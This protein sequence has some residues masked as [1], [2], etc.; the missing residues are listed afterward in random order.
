MSDEIPLGKR[1]DL[2]LE[3]KSAD[4]LKDPEKIAREVVAMLNADGGDVWVGLGEDGEGRAVKVEAIPEPEAS[5]QSL[6]DFLSDSIEPAPSSSEISLA[7]IPAQDG[8]IL[9]ISVVGPTSR[10]YAL[11]KKSG[12]FY[13]RRFDDRILP[14]SREELR[15]AFVGT[16]QSDDEKARTESALR[17]ELKELQQAPRDPSGIF[18]LRIM[19]VPKL[20]VNLDALQESDLLLDPSA[21]GN[22]RAGQTFFLAG[23]GSFHRKGGRLVL[24]ETNDAALSIYRHDGIQLRLPLG[25]FHAG[26]EPGAEKPLYWLTLLEV[27]TSVFRLLSK[28]LRYETLWEE[29]PLENS[30]F[31][32]SV[33]L[34]GLQGWTLRP[35]S[36]QLQQLQGWWNYLLRDPHSSSDR[37]F[38]LAQPF[39]FTLRAIR[40]DPDR[41]GFRLVSR[42]YEAF[43]FGTA[44]LPSEFDQK[45]GRL[46]LSE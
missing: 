38:I 7:V 21:T 36:P 15:E 44:E 23:G 37:D 19:P 35:Y 45:S 5:R 28:M 8:S 46:V 18:W 2:H 34:L 32:S 22:R 20:S 24:G 4:S 11:L 25:K 17:D 31:V 27:P 26:H 39:G 1:E 10:P 12:R 14:M 43:G 16:K 13:W 6:R 41:C 40:D 9:R 30:L 29:L 3:F 42:I 33:A